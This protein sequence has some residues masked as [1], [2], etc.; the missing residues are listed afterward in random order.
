MNQEKTIENY[1]YHSTVTNITLII[2]IVHDAVMPQWTW[3]EKKKKAKLQSLQ[4]VM[5]LINNSI[6][7]HAWCVNFNKCLI[8]FMISPFNDSIYENKGECH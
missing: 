4:I 6:R 5:V 1:D 3:W 7:I 8:I 2:Q